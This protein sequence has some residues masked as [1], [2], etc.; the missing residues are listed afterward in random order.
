M[1]HYGSDPKAASKVTIE[2]NR[3]AIDI[4]LAG[5][6]RAAKRLVWVRVGPWPIKNHNN[7]V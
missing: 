5:H 2:C 1:S 4:F 7:P 6:R 3:A